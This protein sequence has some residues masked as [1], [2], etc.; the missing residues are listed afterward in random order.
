MLRGQIGEDSSTPASESLF[1]ERPDLKVTEKPG[2]YKERKTFNR[3]EEINVSLWKLQGHVS[4]GW[5][6]CGLKLKGRACGGYSDVCSLRV[7]REGTGRV[8]IGKASRPVL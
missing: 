7:Q 5:L 4:P 2:K 6:G 1:E 3:E 8:W